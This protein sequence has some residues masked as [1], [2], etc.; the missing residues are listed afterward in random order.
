VPPGYR[1]VP[2]RSGLG[3]TH[4]LHLATFAIGLV[5]LFLGFA[6][7]VEA[8]ADLGEDYFGAV[9]SVSI[10]EGGAG[11][12]P[13]L[14]FTAG[15]VALLGAL[16]GGRERTVA[17]PIVPALSVGVTLEAMFSTFTMPAEQ[18]AAVGWIMI[19]VLCVLQSV[20]ALIAYFVG[21]S[22]PGNR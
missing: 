5:A 10:Y 4:W 15:F 9:Y 6:P 14:L 8:A 17:G 18:E 19:M 7:A 11:L 3:V 22:D 16:P 1:L 2:A 13:A 21:R 12:T 20:I